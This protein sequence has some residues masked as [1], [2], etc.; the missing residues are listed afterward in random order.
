MPLIPALR[1]QRQMDLCEFKASLVYKISKTT[2]ATQRNTVLENQNQTRA[3]TKQTKQD[4]PSQ[5]LPEDFTTPVKQYK[6][7]TK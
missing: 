6:E 7:S 4:N 3:K 1:R 2:G 5:L